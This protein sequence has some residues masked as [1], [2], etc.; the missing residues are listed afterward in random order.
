MSECLHRNGVVK[1]LAQNTF[2]IGKFAAERLLIFYSNQRHARFAVDNNQVI[3][4]LR[5][6]LISWR[7]LNVLPATV[8]ASFTAS[9]NALLTKCEISASAQ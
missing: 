6:K 2:F 3:W 9:L 8:E 1:K 7:T 5:K 4:A